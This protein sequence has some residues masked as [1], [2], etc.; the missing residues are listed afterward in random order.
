MS[1]ALNGLQD[2]VEELVVGPKKRR[3]TDRGFA[4]AMSNGLGLVAVRFCFC[5]MT[6][7]AFASVVIV[8]MDRENT[9]RDIKEVADKVDDVAQVVKN[10]MAIEQKH[11]DAIAAMRMDVIRLQ[12]GQSAL[13]EHVNDK[14]GIKSSNP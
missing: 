11:D 5:L 12:D 4:H 2:A 14:L 7:L 9:H 1:D 6:A 13:I 3:V 10:V 8:R